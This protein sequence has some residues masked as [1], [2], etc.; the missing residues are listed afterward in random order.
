MNNFTEAFNQWL[1]R[2]KKITIDGKLLVMEGKKY[3][4]IVKEDISSRYAFCFI[5]KATGNVLK[6]AS[7]ATPAK[8]ARGNIYKLG[9][10]GISKYGGNYL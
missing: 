1:E 5:E 8:H 2:A 3:M 6:A 10:E 4:R 9:Q 7:W